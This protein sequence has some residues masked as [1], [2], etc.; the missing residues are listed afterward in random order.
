MKLFTRFVAIVMAAC[1]T[2]TAS[3]QEE[4]KLDYQPFPHMFI[5]LQGGMQATFTNYPLKNLITPNVQFSV[6]AYFTR[7]VG[8][9][10]TASGLW[11]NGGLKSIE[12]IYK[13][14]YVTTNL[15][16]LINLTNLF[17]K[18][19]RNLCNVIL[20][21][22]VGLNCAWDNNDLTG[23]TGYTEDCSLAWGKNKLNHNFRVGVQLGFDISRYIDLNV[24]VGANS[25]ND[26]FNSKHSN[27]DDWQ[28]YALAGFAIKF[29]HKKVKAAPAPEPVIIPEVW[30]TRVDTI[31]YNETLYNEVEF[32]ETLTRNVKFPL[33]GYD[34]DENATGAIN[35]ISDFVAKHTA[36]QVDVKSYADKGTGNAKLNKKYSEQRRQ[37]TVKALVAKGVSE[38]IITSESFG[39]T[40]QPFPNNDDNRVSII[41]VTGKAKKKEPYVV[42]KF[43]TEEKRVRVQ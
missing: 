7:V 23:L 22:G 40:V 38:D 31:W 25:L 17:S 29:A 2:L 14:K 21:G 20:L 8:A 37:G 43:R 42:K 11:C 41:T 35:A 28:G 16:L 36:C 5:G 13:Y 15:D 26:R 6:G 1:F 19:E 30:E 33:R 9:R 27:S 39:D 24:E 3:A 18:K 4:Q 10:I 32:E 34:S 12:K